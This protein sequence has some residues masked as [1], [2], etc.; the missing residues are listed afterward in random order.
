GG[1]PMSAMSR[2]RALV[3]VVAGLGA[4]GAFAQTPPVSSWQPL[5]PTLPLLGAPPLPGT[6]PVDRPRVEIGATSHFGGDQDF[7][8]W[9]VMD[10][11][12]SSLWCE[13]VEGPGLGE[14]LTF[15][16]DVPQ[17]LARVEVQAGAMASSEHF[18]ANDV[19]IG[20]ELRTDAGARLR[21]K[22]TALTPVQTG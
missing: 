15:H 20:W 2:L 11:W 6:W 3:L 19:P 7:A 21:A 1:G 8:P 5:R 17:R 12:A 9:R 4:G 16:F 22:D 18:L 14:A 10:G 13:G